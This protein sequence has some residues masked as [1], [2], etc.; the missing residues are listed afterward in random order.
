M[1]ATMATMTRMTTNAH[2]ANATMIQVISFSLCWSGR[3][4]LSQERRDPAAA[5]GAQDRL[6]LALVE[7]DA[8]PAGAAVEVD[9]LYGQQPHGAGAADASAVAPAAGVGP[10]ERLLQRV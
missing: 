2:P 5:V 8:V 10:R 7:P 4:E 9:G 1:P 3:M 6:Q